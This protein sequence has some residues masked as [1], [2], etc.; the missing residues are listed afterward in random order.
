MSKP[1]DYRAGLK[2]GSLIRDSNSPTM[3]EEDLWRIKEIREN[4]VKVT[5]YRPKGTLDSSFE[6]TINVRNLRK[7]LVSDKFLIDH[8]FTKQGVDTFVKDGIEVL[9]VGVYNFDQ[10]GQIWVDDF[11][12]YVATEEVKKLEREFADNKSSNGTKGREIAKQLYESEWRV[13][14]LNDL[15]NYFLDVHGLDITLEEQI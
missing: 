10:A 3:G 1:Y 2:I 13:A 6:N 11:G 15:Q 8:G 12:F 7:V 9:H 4:L 14:Y 5:R